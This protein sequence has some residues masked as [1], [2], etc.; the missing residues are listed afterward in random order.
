MSIG[1]AVQKG[2]LIY[3]YDQQGKQVM[4]V[5]APGRWPEDGLKSYTPAAVNVQKGTLI[6][7]YDAA[8]HMVGR[9]FPA[10]QMTTTHN[11]KHFASA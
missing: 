5:S 9:P 8:G 1:H 10:Q 2:S 11:P 6:Y 3:I 7:R 4:S